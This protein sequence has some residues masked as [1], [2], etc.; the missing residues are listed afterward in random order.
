MADVDRNLDNSWFQKQNHL[1]LTRS[2]VTKPLILD[3]GVSRASA[4]GLSIAA[5]ARLG[6]G[7]VSAFTTVALATATQ[8]DLDIAVAQGELLE[9]FFENVTVTT[10]NPIVINDG[11]SF[12]T[13][14]TDYRK[15]AINDTSPVTGQA[16]NAVLLPTGTVRGNLNFCGF[17]E[18]NSPAMCEGN[19]GN[20]ALGGFSAFKS[21]TQVRLGTLA[22]YTGG[23]E[24]KY[25]KIA[26]AGLE[27]I[28]QLDFSV[29]ASGTIAGAIAVDGNDE[30]WA[31]HTQVVGAIT[32][33]MWRASEDGVTFDATSEYSNP[34]AQVSSSA[35]LFP[36]WNISLD[37]ATPK[38]M[39][40]A[41][42]TGLQGTGWPSFMGGGAGTYG[43]A[44]GSKE[45]AS[46]LTH[47][48][49]HEWDDGSAYTTGTVEGMRLPWAT[50]SGE[51]EA[52]A[53]GSSSIIYEVDGYDCCEINFEHV[54]GVSAGTPNLLLEFS[55]DGG[56]TYESAD[57]WSFQALGTELTGQSSIIVGVP[58]TTTAVQHFRVRGLQAGVY[59]VVNRI[60]VN[61]TTPRNGGGGWLGGTDQITHLR[62]TLSGGATFNALNVSKRKWTY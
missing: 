59:P 5:G 53:G 61:A 21:A 44:A 46:I 9:V 26:I 13:G 40:P 25:R 19:V 39:C 30:V 6:G 20:L 47:I 52:V 8:D 34:A 31:A 28:N 4:A 32:R 62:L 50:K 55:I 48:G 43:W 60:G 29:D 15:I 16:A 7:G 1:K 41:V 45:T 11:T 36:Q 22:N 57:Y 35:S 10:A 24:I 14:A 58:N 12:R 18:A 42:F 3:A 37:T 51:I 27:P 54:F 56:V 49:P 2:E 33:M 23:G 17:N 38:D